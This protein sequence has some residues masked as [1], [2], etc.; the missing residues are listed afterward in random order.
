[1]QICLLLP[2][3]IFWHPPISSCSYK[4]QTSTK[5]KYGKRKRTASLDNATQISEVIERLSKCGSWPLGSSKQLTEKTAFFLFSLFV[6]LEVELL[7]ATKLTNWF[8]I[9]FSEQT[10]T[11]SIKSLQ[12][13]VCCQVGDVASGWSLVQRSPTECDVSKLVWSWSLDNEALA[14]YGSRA[15]RGKCIFGQFF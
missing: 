2:P 15:S 3:F 9:R 7:S 4:G 8:S 5:S 1:M 11:D 10:H 12:H 6:V 14:H 13:S